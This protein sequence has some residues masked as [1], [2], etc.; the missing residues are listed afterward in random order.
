[1]LKVQDFAVWLSQVE[2]ECVCVCVCVSVCLC[3]QTC[4]ILSPTLSLPLAA[5]APL[6]VTCR[7]WDNGLSDR[8]VSMTSD[9]NV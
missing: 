3:T 5:A 2:L 9:S 4:R 8:S 1:M 7:V 6:G